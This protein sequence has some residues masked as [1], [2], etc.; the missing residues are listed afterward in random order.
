M[1]AAQPERRKEPRPDDP[2]YRGRRHSPRAHIVLPATLDALSG[3]KQTNLLDISREGARLEGGDLPATGKDIILRCGAVDTF[4]TVVWAVAGRCG[5]LFDEPIGLAELVALRQVAVAA[6]LSG[7]T[8]EERQAR[9]DWM[10]GLS[11]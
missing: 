7:I 1:T 10:N 11:R 4:G 3:R 9:A 5:V 8:E 6:E 2:E